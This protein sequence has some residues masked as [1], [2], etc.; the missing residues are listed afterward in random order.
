[1]RQRITS[2]IFLTAALLCSCSQKDDFV[3]DDYTTAEATEENVGIVFRL[4]SSQTTT[5][6]SAE[7]S[8]NYVQGSA[9]EYK[10]NTARVYLYDNTTKLFAKTF[11]LKNIT[12]K[13]S[14]ANGNVIYETEKVSVPQGIYDI[15]VTANTN[16]VI[17]KDTE[18]EFLA[19]IDSITYSKASIEDIS[20][21]I[22]MTN[23][24]T[25][26]LATVIANKNNGED[27]V[28]TIAVER[29]LARLDI[30]KSANEYK[31]T[32]DKGAYYATIKLD[33]FYIVNLAKYYYS[34]RHTAVLTSM[35]EPVWNITSNFGSIADVNGYII[36]PYFFKKS[37]DADKF[38]N[39]DKYYENFYGDIANPNSARWI[40][41]NNVS[42][43][44]NYKTFYCLENCTMAQAQKNGY[45][46][47]VV[48]RAIVEPYNNV[49]QLNSNGALEVVNNT[50][51]YPEEMLY[52]D[53]K[54][55]I[56]PEALQTYIRNT[57]A[58]GDYNIKKYEKTDEG[59][60]CYYKYWIRHLDNYRPTEMGVME[61]AVVRNNLYRML[62]TNVS[63]IGEGGTGTIIVTPDTPDEGEASLQVVLNVKPWIVRDLTDIVL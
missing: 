18:D 38:T 3:A 25:D 15:F 42:A 47:G 58:V 46:T 28:V 32:N 8:H 4:Q 7:D 45:S 61:F 48:F 62:I 59:Y 22:V 11:V 52:F 6:R 1:M 9:D 33:G 50:S 12:R 36:D 35:K 57:G 53:Y 13:G 31:L 21:G 63:D 10:V 54:F 55:F 19:D 23:R 49:Y 37:I 60:R 2:I 43:T 56:S 20:A 41:F 17:N 39:Q 34:Y 51:L 26:N 16:R 29:V 30:A 27:N 5:T 14:D 44:P 24:A 40:A